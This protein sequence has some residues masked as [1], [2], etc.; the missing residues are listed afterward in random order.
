MR[1][2]FLNGDFNLPPVAGVLKFLVFVSFWI[3]M[4]CDLQDRS[5]CDTGTVAL[6]SPYFSIISHCVAT[7]FS[8]IFYHLNKIVRIVIGSKKNPGRKQGINTRIAYAY[9]FVIPNNSQTQLLLFG[10]GCPESSQCG[11]IER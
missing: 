6:S 8:V 11:A 9:V 3:V 4:L 7:S 5:I 2:R 1:D 10:K